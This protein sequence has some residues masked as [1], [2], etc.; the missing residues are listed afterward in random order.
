MAAMK[1]RVV[2]A[3][4]LIT[5]FLVS[6]TAQPAQRFDLLIRNG[7]VMDGTG[8]PWFPA[9]IGIQNGRIAAIGELAGAQGARVIDAAG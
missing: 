2:V 7:R 6:V 5:A 3:A 4:A 9:D 8:N 1:T